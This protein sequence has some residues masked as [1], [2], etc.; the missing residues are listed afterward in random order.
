M[1]NKPNE[2]SLTSVSNYL[3]VIFTQ[4]VFSHQRY[5]VEDCRVTI[6]STLFVCN[7]ERDGSFLCLE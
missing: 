3:K 5:S 6:N 7:L 2:I 1:Q 4:P